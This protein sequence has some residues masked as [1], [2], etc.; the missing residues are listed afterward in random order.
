MLKIKMA[1]GVERDVLENTVIYPS[2]NTAIRNRFEI[3]MDSEAMSLDDF[4]ALFSD[5]NTS[6]IHLINEINADSEVQ[7][8]DTVY[9]DYS[10]I[11]S[12]GLQRAM[13]SDIKTGEPTETI[14][15]VAVL[16]QPTYIEKQL[17]SLG[18]KI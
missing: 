18:I 13:S 2:Y 17:K 6:E 4:I 1:D 14:N 5:E 7:K 3:H 11:S 10:I 15:L 8:T 12:I 9:Y 16:E